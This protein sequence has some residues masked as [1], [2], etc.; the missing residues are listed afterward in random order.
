VGLA[1]SG[2]GAP[3]GL[4]SLVGFTLGSPTSVTQ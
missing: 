1:F 4:A 2:F 3:V